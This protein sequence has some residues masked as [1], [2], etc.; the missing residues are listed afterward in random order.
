MVFSFC[1][2]GGGFPNPNLALVH[3]Y[4]QHAFFVFVNVSLDANTLKAV[5]VIRRK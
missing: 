2:F 5:S 1:V 4:K 3:C